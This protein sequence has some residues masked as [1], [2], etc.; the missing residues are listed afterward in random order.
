MIDFI[1][2]SA[3]VLFSI[4]SIGFLLS[5]ILR[6]MGVV[7]ALWGSGLAICAWVLLYKFSG[8]PLQF[9]PV[10]LISLWALRLTIFLIVTRVWVGEKDP[11]YEALQKKWGRAWQINTL[12]N[13]YLQASL[14]V[15]LI[16][17]LLPAMHSE[18]KISGLE[19]YQLIALILFFL[20]LLG[21]SMADQTLHEFKNSGQK[22]VCRNGLWAISRHPNYFFEIL[23]W[24][25]LAIYMQGFPM[26][27]LATFSPLTI[28]IITRFITGPYTERLSLEKRPEAYKAYQNEVP[29]IIPNPF[30]RS[31]K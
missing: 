15:V 5:L 9:I 8:G 16:T 22:G 6:N 20:A 11:R 13:F 31:P 25:A 21:Q 3:I 29:M 2:T 4:M 18:T 26:G 23:M 19:P 14:Q 30:I 17:V 24:A 27:W 10:V 7:D 12:G 1:T 28:L